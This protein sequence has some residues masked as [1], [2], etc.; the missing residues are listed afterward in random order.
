MN[1]ATLPKKNAIIYM[2][3]ICMSYYALSLLFCFLKS[4]EEMT[5]IVFTWILQGDEQNIFE[6][7]CIQM[8]NNVQCIFGSSR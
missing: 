1:T 5:Y 8:S 7:N 3:I 2:V 6:T 4:E